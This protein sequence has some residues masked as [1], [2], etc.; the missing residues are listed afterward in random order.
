MTTILGIDAAWT[1]K[2]PSGMVLMTLRD[3][4]WH[5]VAVAPSHAPL[6]GLAQGRP[7]DW[8]DEA[9]V[10]DQPHHP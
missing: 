3:A 6:I 10:S 2:E 8:S 5:C 1:A 4:R 9:I 7:I